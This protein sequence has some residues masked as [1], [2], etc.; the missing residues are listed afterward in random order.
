MV[1]LGDEGFMNGGGDG[2]YAYT[3]AEGVDFAQNLKVPVRILNHSE[4]SSKHLRDYLLIMSES[5][6]WY[7][8]SLSSILESVATARRKRLVHK[9]RRCL[10][11]C[12][13]ALRW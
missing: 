2:S 13:Q 9:P 10:P 1:T 3:T 7:L 6:L 5:R 8:P 11:C 4:R 12:Q